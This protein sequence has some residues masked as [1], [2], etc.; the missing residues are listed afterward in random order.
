MRL[1]IL[2]LA[3]LSSLTLAAQFKDVKVQPQQQ[4]KTVN[5]EVPAFKKNLTYQ[6]PTSSQW[7]P[8]SSSYAISEELTVAQSVN[9]LP[10]LITGMIPSDNSKGL[11][12]VAEA[13]HYLTV[14]A[15][16]MQIE[17]APAE[18]QLLSSDT[19]DLGMHHIKYQQMY[20]GIPV[21]G[22]E[23]IV[24]GT[25]KGMAA[26]N[27]RYQSTPQLATTDPSLTPA[28]AQLTATQDLGDLLIP[29][30]HLGIFADHKPLSQE[31]VVYPTADGPKLTYHITAYKNIV[32]RW[33][34]FV[35]AH[36]GNILRKHESICRLHNH[37]HTHECSHTAAA[38][39]PPVVSNSQDLF[40]TNR[41][42]NTF[43]SGNN[44]F[45]IDAARTQMFDAAS[46]SM[47][48]EPVGTIWT[49]DAFDTSPQSSGFT[50]DHVS[51]SS[52]SFPNKKVAV[53][54]HINGGEAFE[55]FIDVHNRLSI[56]GQG[57]N[58]I[59]L[60]NVADEDGQGMDNAF[61][62][63]I[64]MFYGNGRS[65]FRELA[66][67]LDVA[68]HEMTH[69]VI[70]STANLEYQ[71][72]SGALNESFADVFGAMIDRDDW[73][74]GEDV[75]L[76][77]AFPSGALRSMEDP[78]NGA[79]TN[80]FGRGWQPRHYNERFTGPEDNSGVHINSG[81]PNHA[82][83]R[84][85]TA[86]GVG[87]EKAEKVWY[88]ALTSYL[89]KSSQFVDARVATER[90]TM[91]LYGSTELAAVRAAWD[92]VGVVG[93]GG[94]DYEVD[95]QG[96][97]GEDFVL[98]S[99]VEEDIFGDKSQSGVY[100]AT[101]EGQVIFNPLSGRNPISKPSVT[102]N[103]SE[104]LY[105][106]D[107]LRLA[108]AFINW[109]TDT[110]EAD[111]LFNATDSNGNQIQWR[112]AAFS[113]DGSKLSALRIAEEPLIYVFDFDSGREKF[114]PLTNP[115]FSQD[116]TATAD[117]LYADVMEWDFSG[118]YIMY[119]SR[120]QLQSIFD[121]GVT[122]WDI[123][124][125][126]VWDNT[127][128]DFAPDNQIEK[129]FGSLPE[130]TSIGNPTFSKNSPHII[131]FDEITDGQN[132]IRGLNIETNTLGT[133]RSNNGRLGYPS[134]S[135]DDNAIIFDVANLE[136]LE[137]LGGVNLADDKIN[138]TGQAGGFLS[139][140]VGIRW[141]VWFGN[142][143][144]VLS[145]TED[146]QLMAISLYPNPTTGALTIDVP[147][148]MPATYRVTVSDLMGKTIHNSV[149]AKS[150]ALGTLPA[151]QYLV[152]ITSEKGIH[153]EMITKL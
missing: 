7:Q 120:N 74:I 2:T 62:N 71:G 98:L 126:K 135:N 69:G 14:A 99:V 70:Q 53:S 90:A 72:E 97:P 105:V 153:T 106:N 26:V 125:I 114:F 31:L 85:A 37:T 147:H 68:G 115:T 146:S 51:S 102:D 82:F 52:I 13:M 104:I 10:V 21:Y 116:P 42:I 57:G 3:L 113:K 38:P 8:T 112:N 36:T 78:H 46:S 11:A 63:G 141:G 15:P 103:G 32:E 119:D 123:G 136:G 64:A 138:S 9:G 35:D 152:T 75:V 83:F 29:A 28:A 145:D 148:D 81:I 39:V 67:G 50:Y 44:F 30:D 56:N 88:R 107:S 55:Y 47:P 87:K 122:Y 4:D 130:G 91:D 121:D 132:N 66:R 17:N 134:F 149:G 129:L 100:V 49:I 143:S 108:Y 84:F 140:D 34:Y 12:P 124:F 23:V 43:Q 60:V 142:G 25:V 86:S 48:N 54:A 131:A 58:I 94:N 150:I 1:L 45:M 20:Q 33:E 151:A 19:D 27:G 118:E 6:R 137:I 40:N 128:N 41:S 93:Q 18:W 79:Q 139:F 127:T 16:L 61:W 80:D 65:A 96:N 109:E 73:R 144:R 117:V 110:K 22:S 95:V 133:I 101:P 77:S 59:S 24:H 89:T 5:L 92:A 76:T 111:F